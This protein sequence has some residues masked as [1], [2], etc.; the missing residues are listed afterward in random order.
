MVEK[1]KEWFNRTGYPLEILG[2]SILVKNQFNVINSSLYHDPENN[3]SR[4]LD[5]YASRT[6][7]NKESEISLQLDLLIECKK[8]DKPFIL[9]TSESINRKDI[10][11]GDWYGVD[12]PY[13]RILINNDSRRIKLPS[14]SSVGFKLIQGF[15]NSDETIHKATNTVLKSFMDW[16]RKEED[17]LEYYIKDNHHVIAIPILLVDAPFYE[18]KLNGN[19]EL[20]MKEINSGLFEYKSKLSELYPE[21]FPIP[22]IQAG[23]LEELLI[24]IESFATETMSLL[25]KNP[26]I[27]IKNFHNTNVNITSNLVGNMSKKNL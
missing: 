2:E 8:S 1:L 15:T 26:L 11:L 21:P 27:N 18:A 23:K 24:S 5:L 17:Y 20:E 4:E 9:V 22:I 25:T 7:K 14:Q 10:S 6:W 16:I 19:D 3:I 12:G 13:I